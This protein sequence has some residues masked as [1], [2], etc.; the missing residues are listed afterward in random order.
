TVQTALLTAFS[1]T[2]TPSL[3]PGGVAFTLRSLRGLP[4]LIALRQS[5]QWSTACFNCAL[6]IFERPEMPLRLASAYSW[7]LVRPPG[8][9]WERL[10][11]RRELDIS[12]CDSDDDSLASPALARSLLTVRAAISSAR[13]SER[14]ASF[15]DF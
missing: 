4:G 2:A 9:E 15:W 11:P 8:P 12:R 3:R 1:L 14:P 13:P 5:R 6:F 10:P 7:S